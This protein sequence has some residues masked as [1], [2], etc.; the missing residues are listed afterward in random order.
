MMA[1][2]VVTLVACPA[3]N[4]PAGSWCVRHGRTQPGPLLCCVAR[5][6]ALE[7]ALEMVDGL[8]SSTGLDVDERSLLEERVRREILDG[9]TLEE[10]ARVEGYRRQSGGLWLN[11]CDDVVTLEDELED[12]VQRVV[13]GL[14]AGRS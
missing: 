1:G 13:D 9:G 8:R 4:A 10:W 11:E 2:D 5:G 12:E 14:E 3:C 7:A 6:V